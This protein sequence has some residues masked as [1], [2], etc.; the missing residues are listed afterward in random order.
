MVMVMIMTMNITTMVPASDNVSRDKDDGRDEN[1]HRDQ[2]GDHDQTH[3]RIRNQEVI[4]M[5]I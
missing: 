1:E 2:H 4:M 5:V 3:L